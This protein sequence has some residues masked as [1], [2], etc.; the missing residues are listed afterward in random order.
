[1]RRRCGGRVGLSP[2]EVL[3]QDHD[4]LDLFDPERDG[5]EDPD[6]ETNQQIAMGGYRPAVWFRTF[7]NMTLRDGRRLFRR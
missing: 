2:W 1:L 3:F 7:D 4:I 5:I 6:S